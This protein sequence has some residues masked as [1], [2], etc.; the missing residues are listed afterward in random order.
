V[1]TLGVHPLVER[2]QQVKV[3][4]VAL[5]VVSLQT[6]TV[7]EAV[8]ERELLLQMLLQLIQQRVVSDYQIVLQDRLFFTQVVVLLVVTSHKLLLLVE[9][10]VEVV[11]E[12]P[13]QMELMV[14]PTL[15]AEEEVLVG[16]K[17]EAQVVQA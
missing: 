11:V 10:A 1:L 2:V 9:M 6:H 15:E 4:Q 14:Q 5:T 16:V 12:T 3:T 13:Q 7:Q 8:V 17:L